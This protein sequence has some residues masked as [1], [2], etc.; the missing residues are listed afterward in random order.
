M[1]PTTVELAERVAAIPPAVV[2][3]AHVFGV[4]VAD[5]TTW[6]MF[7]YAVSLLAWHFKTKWLKRWFE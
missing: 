2:A 1:S 3:G 6:I 7:V 4:P 5:I